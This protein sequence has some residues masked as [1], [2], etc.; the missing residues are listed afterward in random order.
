VKVPQGGSEIIPIYAFEDDGTGK[1]KVDDNG[2]MVRANAKLQFDVISKGGK[3]RVGWRLWRPNRDSPPKDW[4]PMDKDHAGTV[5]GRGPQL[6]VTGEDQGDIV[7][8]VGPV[9]VEEPTLV[10]PVTVG[11][12]D[13]N[14]RPN[15]PY[16]PGSK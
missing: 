13:P 6:V 7:I 14:W 8:G 10:I 4:R 1:P 3:C 5:G 12:P 2:N 11:P 15:E 9:G 16:N